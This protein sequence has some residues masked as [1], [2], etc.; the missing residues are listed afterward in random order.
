M[1]HRHAIGVALEK[2]ADEVANFAVIVDDEKVAGLLHAR[3]LFHYRIVICE[4]ARTSPAHTTGRGAMPVNLWKGINHLAGPDY[5][6]KR[7]SGNI[8]LQRRPLPEK[9]Q[10]RE[11]PNL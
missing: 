9:L 10:K 3:G 8:L 2:M 11:S 7:A 6:R 4:R 5:F 1:R